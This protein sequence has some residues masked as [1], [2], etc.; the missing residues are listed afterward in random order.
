MVNFWRGSSGFLEIAM[1]NFTSRLLFNLL[2][3][4]RLKDVVSLGIFQL[5]LAYFVIFKSFFE[6]AI[7]Y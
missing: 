4:S 1:I 5:C 3:S 2:L 7:F 6:S